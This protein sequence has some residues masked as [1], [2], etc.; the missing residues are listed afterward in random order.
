VLESKSEEL[1]NDFKAIDG[2]LSQWKCSFGIKLQK[3]HGKKDSAD[4]VS[5]E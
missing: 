4:A 3:E 2:W 1:A 5:A